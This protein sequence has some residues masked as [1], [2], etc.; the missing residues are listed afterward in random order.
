MKKKCC[1]PIV[2]VVIVLAVSLLVCSC[3][4]KIIPPPK[5]DYET[6]AVK[7]NIIADP[8]LNLDE[9]KAHTLHACFY[10]LKDPNSF[11][12]LADDHDGLYTLL[13]CGLFDAG[14]ASSKTVVVNPDE[15]T[16]LVFDRAES[17]RFFAVVADIME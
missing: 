12:Q 1:Y 10:Q 3:A 8:L 14:V 9:G 11:N 6:N 4:P 15:K 17:A 5:W 7:I 13:R 2:F 16:T